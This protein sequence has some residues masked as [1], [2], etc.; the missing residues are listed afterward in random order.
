MDKNP[1][2]LA[3]SPADEAKYNEFQEFFEGVQR[4]YAKYFSTQK[5]NQHRLSDYFTILSGKVP[6]AVRLRYNEH[7]NLDEAIK[8]EVIEGYKKIFGEHADYQVI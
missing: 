7:S 4:K 6:P 8:N 3:H 1:S 5:R 2:G